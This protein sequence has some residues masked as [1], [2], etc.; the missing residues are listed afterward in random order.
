MQTSVLIRNV[1][2]AALTLVLAFAIVACDPVIKVQGTVRDRNGNPLENV[3][4][5]LQTEGRLPHKTVTAKDGSFAV[6]IVG[7]DPRDTKL[8]FQKEGYKT[9]EKALGNEHGTAVDATLESE[10]R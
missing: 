8:V 10:V 9:V 7:A 5:S 6:G 2:F 1:T 4:V 3:T